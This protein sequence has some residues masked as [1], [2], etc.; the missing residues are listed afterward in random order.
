MDHAM[1]IHRW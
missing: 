1:K